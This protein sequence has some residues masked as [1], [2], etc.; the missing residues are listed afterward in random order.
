[1]KVQEA[2]SDIIRKLPAIGKDSTS[3]AAQGGY[4]YRGIEQITASLQPLLGEFGVIIV[5]RAQVVSIQPAPGMKDFWT[6][7]VLSVAWMIVGPEGDTIEACTVGIGRDNADKGANKA[8]S[9]A[10]K[11]LL[12]DLLCISDRKDDSDGA[13]YT[14]GTSN[15]ADPNATFKR[16]TQL[17]PETQAALRKLA[18]ETGHRLTLKQLHDDPSWHAMVIETINAW[19]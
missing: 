3:A 11:Y 5:P 14:A 18:T 7:T 6:D 19:E 1:V 17:Q 12:L 10:Y 15:K 13:D 2:V 16:L 9:Q 4:P 8:M